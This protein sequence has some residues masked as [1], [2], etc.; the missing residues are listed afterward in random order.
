[1]DREKLAAE[2]LR[3]GLYGQVCPSPMKALEIALAGSEPEDLIF[4]GGSTFVVA[5]VLEN[6]NGL[7]LNA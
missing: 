5:E 7:S 6:V 1:M 3:F 2:A 4:I